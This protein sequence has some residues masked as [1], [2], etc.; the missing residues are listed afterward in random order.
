MLAFNAST[1]RRPT[2]GTKAP[3]G[4]QIIDGKV[5]QEIHGTVYTLGIKADNELVEYPPKT[6]AAQML[7]DGAVNALTAFI[8]LIVDH[9]NVNDSLLAIR[10]NFN[11]K[12]PR[13]IIAQFDNLDLLFLSCGGLS[14][15]GENIGQNQY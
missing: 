10:K 14:F 2:P 13:Q 7:Q 11:K 5:M 15:D 8:P 6:S 12:H 9:I 1:Q 4:V 3:N